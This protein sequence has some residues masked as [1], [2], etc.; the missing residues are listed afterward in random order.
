M[1]AHVIEAGGGA[2]WTTRPASLRALLSLSLR[3]ST[4]TSS[5]LPEVVNI[6]NPAPTT[7]YKRLV[8]KAVDLER[9]KRSSNN[10]ACPSSAK[11]SART[12]H[13]GS[14]TSR[15]LS[16]DQTWRQF[17]C[18]GPAGEVLGVWGV[19]QAQLFVALALTSS[20]SATERAKLQTQLDVISSMQTSSSVEAQVLK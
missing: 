8:G 4:S 1:R 18:L 3:T 9:M 14:V 6:T 15:A 2:C 16:H 20:A 11:T 7:I 5:S 12:T 13:S 10:E 17:E 19:A